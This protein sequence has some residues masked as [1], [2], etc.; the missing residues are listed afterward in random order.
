M[1]KFDFTEIKEGDTVI[2]KTK[3]GDKKTFCYTKPNKKESMMCNDC[4]LNSDGFTCV[5][6]DIGIWKEVTDD[7]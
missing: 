3:H 5:P 7:K 1:Q 4:D 6:C 2:E